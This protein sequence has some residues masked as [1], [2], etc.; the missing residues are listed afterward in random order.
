LGES[1]GKERPHYYVLNAAGEPE[2][3]SVLEWGKWLEE[4]STD[5][6]RVI[7]Q[8]K[9]ESQDGEI[10]VSTVFI[11]LDYNFLGE[12]PPILWET[13]IL[14]GPLHGYQE[15]YSSRGAA[16]AGHQEACDLMR[17]AAKRIKK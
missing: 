16:L 5:R 12:G 2:P 6:T 14:G 4:A 13:M 10:M 9:D 3:A 1:E 7:A 11:G 8:D 17:K 15:R